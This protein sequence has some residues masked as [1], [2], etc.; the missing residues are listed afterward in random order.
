MKKFNYVYIVFVLILLIIVFNLIEVMCFRLFG[1]IYELLYLGIGFYMLFWVNMIVLI[2][3]G[4]IFKV[5]SV[6]N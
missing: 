4:F 5:I 6:K 1:E 2:L 3:F